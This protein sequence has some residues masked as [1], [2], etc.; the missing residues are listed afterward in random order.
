MHVPRDAHLLRIFTGED[1]RYH[2]KPLYE[3]IVLQ[4]LEKKQ[5][6]RPTARAA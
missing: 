3:A 2:G 4:A 5:E 6:D 1:D